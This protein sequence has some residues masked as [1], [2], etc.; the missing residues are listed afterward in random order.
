MSNKR[1]FRLSRTQKKSERAQRTFKQ[2]RFESLENRVMFT[3]DLPPLVDINPALSTIGSNPEA[4]TQVGSI[5]YF[6][7]TTNSSGRELWKSDGTAVGT[8]LVKDIRVGVFGSNPQNLTNLNGTLY[9]SADDGVYGTELWKSDGTE[10]GT[11]MV[12]NVRS[13]AYGSEPRSLT[14]V[15]GSLYFSAVD[16]GTNRELWKSDGTDAG[17]VLVM[18]I[19]AGDN[20]S[21]LAA[22]SNVNG[23]LFFQA[24]DGTHGYELWKSDGTNA[25][26]SLVKDILPGTSGS[27]I[28]S[29]TVFNGKLYFTAADGTHGVELW[30]SD[31]TEVGTE[32]VNDTHPGNAGSF[33]RNLIELNGAL[34]FTASDGTIAEGLWKTDGTAAGTEFVKNL[35][36]G[37][38]AFNFVNFTNVSGTLYFTGNYGPFSYGSFSYGYRGTELWKSNGTSGGTL[39]VRDFHIDTFYYNLGNLT[40]L[41]GS[42]FFSANDGTNGYELWKSDG[43]LAGTNLV[44]DINGGNADSR[45]SGLTN[46]DGTLYFK[47]ESVSDGFQLWR[48]DGTFGGTNLFKKIASGSGD[49]NIGRLT[50][51]DGKLYFN[52][53]RSVWKSDGTL[54]GTTKATNQVRLPNLA[55]SPQSVNLNGVLYFSAN[56]AFTG[57]ELWK[58]DGTAGGTTLV[59]DIWP[60]MIG[61]AP[62]ALTV[63]DGMLY[64]IA[65]DEVHGEELWKSDGTEAGTQLVQDIFPGARSSSISQLFTLNQTLFFTAKNAASGIE[66]WKSD[67]TAAGTAVV[68]NIA[69]GVRDSNPTFLTNVNG[70]LYFSADS[71]NKGVE[72]W[73]SNGTEAGTSLVKEIFA[74]SE[75]SWPGNLTN[76]NGT[77]YFRATDANGTELW[78]SNGTP[79]GTV[80][81]SNIRE[82]SAGSY[83]WYLTNVDGTLYFQAYDSI[84]GFELWRSNGAAASTVLVK[85]IFT[86]LGGSDPR[87]LTN[88]NGM[89]YFKSN[90]G[91][92]GEELWMSDGT[93]SG[94]SMVIDVSAGGSN[95]ADIFSI[96]N[97][98][99]FTATTDSYGRELYVVSIQTTPQDIALSNATI[100]ENLP[101]N[102]MVG[103][104]STIDPDTNDAFVYSLVSGL[105]DQDNAQ[106]AIV[107]NQLQALGSLDFETQSSYSIRVRSTDKFG[108]YLEE[109]L[110][111]SVTN[112]NTLSAAVNP[113]GYLLIADIDAVGKNNNLTI[114][115]ASGNLVIADLNEEFESAPAGWTLS[116]NSKSLSHPVASFRSVISINAL[117]GE[118]LLTVDFSGGALINVISFDGGDALDKIAVTGRTPASLVA[119]FPSASQGNLRISGVSSIFYNNVEEAN[120]GV[121]P[122]Q[123]IINLPSSIPSTVVTL[124]DDGIVGNQILKL[125]GVPVTTKFVRP[126]GSLSLLGGNTPV[127]VT[128]LPDLRSSLVLGTASAPLESIDFAG[129]VPLALTANRSLSAYTTNSIVLSTSDSDLAT[130]G[131]GSIELNSASTIQLL[132]GSSITT[133]NGNITLLATN[134]TSRAN[135]VGLDVEDASIQSTLGSIVLRGRGGINEGVANIGVIVA[136]STVRSAGS[137][138]SVTGTGG[139]RGNSSLNHGVRVNAKGVIS[140]G[141]DVTVTGFAG[142]GTGGN[143]FG[144]TVFDVGSQITS[145]GGVVT[146]RG[147]GGDFG[148]SSGTNHGVR[149]SNGGVITSTGTSALVSVSGFGGASSGNNNVGVFVV[150]AGSQITSASGIVFVNGSGGG[151]NSSKQ[152]YGVWVNSGGAI[153]SSGTRPTNV[154]GTGGNAAGTGSENYGIAISGVGSKLS[155]T[156]GALDIFSIG[157]SNSGALRLTNGGSIS[158]TNSNIVL[159][160]DSLSIAGTPLG[161]I[162]A[163]AGEVSIL[164]RT[165]GTRIALGG[166]DQLV[167]SP[168]TLGLSSTELNRISGANLT[169]GSVDSGKITV[170][171]SITRSTATNLSLAS[172]NEIEIASPINTAGGSLSLGG[173]PLATTRPTAAGIDATASSITLGASLTID[174]S[175]GTV[176]T[177]YTQLRTV[178]AV[179]LNSARLLIGGSTPTVTGKETFTIVSASSIA[180]T[181]LGLADGSL[182]NVHGYLYK[183]KYNTTTVQL[184]SQARLFDFDHPGAVTTASSYQSVLPTD[185][186]TPANGFGWSA[187]VTSLS[188]TTASATPVEL[189]RDKHVSS[190]QRSFFVSAEVGKTYNVRVLLGDQSSRSVAISVDGGTTFRTVTTAANQYR[191]ELFSGIVAIADRIEIRIKSGNTTAWAVDGIEVMQVANAPANMR[192]EGEAS[193]RNYSVPHDAYFGD[194]AAWDSCS[195]KRKRLC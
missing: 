120:L 24:N 46:I 142:S 174:I 103:E 63:L 193:A 124:G 165:A 15:H 128:S 78:K 57:Y 91:I 141:A 133:A 156:G 134:A 6:S 48:S 101:A 45:P 10:A 90:D 14:N 139:G 1:R 81:V 176:D 159:R 154:L 171:A 190:L 182:V 40:N 113:H 107:G 35:R 195:A 56:N 61:S 118:D 44:R 177:G 110:L 83:P 123:M 84:H 69:P 85:D 127:I 116:A 166:L 18:D 135:S 49:S 153:S 72:L 7:S 16:G 88:V 147:G 92:H 26:T 169:I 38:S 119:G 168:L 59:K 39:I 189:Y 155:A 66:L 52:A 73:K 86:G 68:R 130:S 98:L 100:A 105:G 29:Q 149:V 180:G 138:V 121:R 76:V 160:A 148:G 145:S 55:S 99:F 43:S 112:T 126:S 77:L 146:V 178:S 9:F 20:S 75:S 23:T 33:S 97:K 158:N 89:L 94:T 19:R 185:L 31:G 179:N 183:I 93:A 104:F 143:N 186:F 4:I 17:T 140:G 132:I 184:T 161:S 21:N 80:L 13:G 95:P 37:T 96:N 12:K 117:R 170:N 34:Y 192:A 65:N 47:A 74:G 64:F 11:V 181:F 114:S 87:G 122:G 108:L 194:S 51:L 162:T 137:T 152:N 5:F 109:S 115:V 187:A 106:F 144:V 151:N 82:G 173:G 67:G 150:N 136:G 50:N 131:F 2:L 36:V 3:V 111:I 28:S 42:L 129:A 157:T 191:A 54:A 25:G 102:T 125:S 62:S 71:P 167:T 163:G 79:S 27:A 41:N 32:L 164:P 30:K 53:Q 22:F 175:N 58:N 188:R 70:T 172:A 60:G 8:V